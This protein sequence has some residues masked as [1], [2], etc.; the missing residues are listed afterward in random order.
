MMD[1]TTAGIRKIEMPFREQHDK[2]IPLLKQIR[3]LLYVSAFSVQRWS[4]LV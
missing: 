2:E 3:K 4:L 1:Y